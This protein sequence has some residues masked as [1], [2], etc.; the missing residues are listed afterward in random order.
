MALEEAIPEPH[1]SRAQHSSVCCGLAD[2]KAAVLELS[3][4]FVQRS[5]VFRRTGDIHTWC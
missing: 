3:Q 5:S 1:H 4:C 2:T